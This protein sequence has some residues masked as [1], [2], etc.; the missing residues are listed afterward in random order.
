MFSKVSRH[1]ENVISGKTFAIWGLSFKPNTDDMREAPSLVLIESLL[2]AGASV[3]VFDPVAMEEAKHTLKDSVTYCTDIY[4]AAEDA[5]AII[6][7]TEWNEFRLPDWERLAKSMKDYV[8][9]DGRNIYEQQVLASCGF[10]YHGIGI[11]EGNAVL[12]K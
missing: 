3:K 9:F 12:V 10:K 8:V 6:L 1:F 2:A 4:E 5:D 11:P 7:V